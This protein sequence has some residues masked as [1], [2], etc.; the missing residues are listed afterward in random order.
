MIGPGKL[1][2][3]SNRL[4]EFFGRKALQANLCSLLSATGVQADIKKTSLFFLLRNSSGKGRLKV[5]RYFQGSSKTPRKW[6]DGL[7]GNR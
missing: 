4:T 5:T 3:V 2:A 7:A 6:S 1:P